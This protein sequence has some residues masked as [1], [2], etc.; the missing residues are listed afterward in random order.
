MTKNKYSELN[1]HVEENDKIQDIDDLTTL[2]KEQ[3][4]NSE[5][6]DQYKMNQSH[7]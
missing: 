3:V 2:S 1:Y 6:N 5:E 7:E 4:Q